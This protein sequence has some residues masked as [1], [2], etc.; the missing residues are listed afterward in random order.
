MGGQSFPIEADF[1]VTEHCDKLSI[2]WALEKE[3][4]RIFRIV[5]ELFTREIIE[6]SKSWTCWFSLA[7]FS[8]GIWMNLWL[9]FQVKAWR[10]KHME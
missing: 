8:M 2:R 1:C 10:A 9:G 5:N 6:V 3:Q 7:R 4:Q